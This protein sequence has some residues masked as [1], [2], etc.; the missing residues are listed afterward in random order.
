MVAHLCVEGLQLAVA[1]G[2]VVATVQVHIKHV[3]HS[4]SI[5]DE[6]FKV[7]SPPKRHTVPPYYRP[8]FSKNKKGKRIS[9]LAEWC[10]FQLRST[11]Q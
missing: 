5:W 10:K 4:S 9:R 1:Q 6:Q 11:F 3:E 8:Q 7:V 2:A